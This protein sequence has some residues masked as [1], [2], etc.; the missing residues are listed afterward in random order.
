MDR[1]RGADAMAG[2]QQK[3]EVEEEE[4]PDAMDTS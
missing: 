1:G 4:D 2:V 3:D